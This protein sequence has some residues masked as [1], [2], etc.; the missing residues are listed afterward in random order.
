MKVHTWILNPSN[1]HLKN[2]LVKHEKYG[3]ERKRW[4]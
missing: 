4:L 3:R 2:R 1:A